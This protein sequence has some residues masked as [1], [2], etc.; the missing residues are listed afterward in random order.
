MVYLCPYFFSCCGDKCLAKILGGECVSSKGPVFPSLMGRKSTQQE[1][2]RTA[3][4]A[5]SV[6]KMLG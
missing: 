1:L 2:T 6:K 4:I 3:H 5:A